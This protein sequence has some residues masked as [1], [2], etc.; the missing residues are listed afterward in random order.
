M[1]DLIN[2]TI[3]T[4]FDDSKNASMIFVTTKGEIY[5]LWQEPQM[6]TQSKRHL[7]R[8]RSRTA[9]NKFSLKHVRNIPYTVTGNL[10]DFIKSSV[11][12]TEFFKSPLD[13]T[14]CFDIDYMSGGTQSTTAEITFNGSKEV[15]LDFITYL[16]G[17]QYQSYQNSG[18]NCPSCAAEVLYDQDHCLY[19]RT[20]LNWEGVIDNRIDLSKIH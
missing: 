19:C 6:C 18:Y 20:M 9:N 17:H 15:H 2:K 8:K 7:K 10:A 4:I 5:R 12:H 13:E 16:L 1:N 14:Y 11:T 3:R